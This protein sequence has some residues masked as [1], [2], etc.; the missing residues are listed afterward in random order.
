MA[1]AARDWRSTC[2][3]IACKKYI[4]AY[5]A[6]MNGADAIVFA[7]GIGENSPEVRD[8][9]LRRARLARHLARRGAQRGAR[10]APRAAS[11]RTARASSSG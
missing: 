11:T 9:Y 6:A 10:R 5:L 1:T 4:G 8:A 7:G 3:A 2:S